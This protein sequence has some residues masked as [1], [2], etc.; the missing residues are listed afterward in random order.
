MYKATMILAINTASSQTAVALLQD[1]ALKKQDCWDSKNAEAEKLMPSIHKLLNGQSYE[2]I[3]TVI[4]IKGPGSFTGL[5][6]GITAANTIAYLN[7]CNLKTIN[8]FQLWWSALKI[9]QPE[10]INNKTALLIY[11]GSGGV[12]ISHHDKQEAGHLVNM[13][14]L[15]EHLAQHGVKEVFGDITADQREQI[16]EAQFVDIEVDFG[17][18]IEEIVKTDIL[19]DE[20]IIKPLYIKEPSI[21]KS[22]KKF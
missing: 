9:S 22:K 8:T 20:K 21:S 14:D 12:Y 15:N 16:K 7:G 1:E 5:R 10:K 4:A 18:I 13:P 17:K 6:V 3:K 19:K 11:A 2:S